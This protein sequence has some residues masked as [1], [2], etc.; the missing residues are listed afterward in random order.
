MQ[1]QKMCKNP[2]INKHNIVFGRGRVT[3][4]AAIRTGVRCKTEMHITRVSCETLGEE[5]HCGH[6]LL[7]EHDTCTDTVRHSV[8]KSETA[9]SSRDLEGGV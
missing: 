6:L 3:H 8:S 1:L 4:E 5:S 2:C 7:Q 9:D